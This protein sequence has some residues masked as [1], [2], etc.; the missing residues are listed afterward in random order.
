M[1]NPGR[2][3]ITLTANL[4]QKVDDFLESLREI[5]NRLTSQTVLHTALVSSKIVADVDQ[6]RKFVF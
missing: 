4:D 3:I 1:T 5:H 6:L 2:A